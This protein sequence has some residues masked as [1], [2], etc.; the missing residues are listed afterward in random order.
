[1]SATAKCMAM[2]TWKRAS[3]PRTRPTSPSAITGSKSDGGVEQLRDLVK[4]NV[5]HGAEE[6]AARS[7]TGLIVCLLADD[8]RI[9]IDYQFI[10][11]D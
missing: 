5:A 10:D 6:P 7:C 8:G 9:R 2:P 3:P 11:P 1:M 4:F